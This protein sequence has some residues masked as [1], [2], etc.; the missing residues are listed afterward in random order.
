MAYNL[1]T[2]ALNVFEHMAL[3]ETLARAALAAPVL[4]FYHWTAGPAVTF[5]YGQFY[6]SVRR[7]SAPQAGPPC[8]RPTGGGMVFHGQDLTFSLVFESKLTRP[9]EIYAVLHG[10]VERA[11]SKRR[12]ARLIRQG[13]VDAAAYAPQAAGAAA[14]CFVNPVEN[15]LL[16]NGKKILGGAIR[17]FGAV[18]L[19]QGSLQCPC[20]RT[21][22]G[23]RRAVT[24]GAAEALGEAFETAP[25]DGAL[26]ARARKLACAQY[27]TRAWNEKF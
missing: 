22:P 18:V 4:R 26:L 23:F 2:P 8:R 3:D 11:L 20:A 14:G 16:E 27:Q 24:E 17:R 19:Y 10:A 21:D 15:D 1:L 9:Q 25:A 7:Q 5:G 13:A 6:D 12:A